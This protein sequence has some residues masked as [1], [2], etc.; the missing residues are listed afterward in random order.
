MKHPTKLVDTWVFVPDRA[1]EVLNR[2]PK[3]G[4]LIFPYLGK[5]VSVAFTKT[6][7]LLGIKDLRF[8]DLRHECASWLFEQ[9]H[10]IPQVASVTGHKAWTSLER[11]THIEAIGDKYAGWAR[12]H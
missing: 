1:W 3:S 7:K 6:C 11:Y 12:P 8:H 9:K 4:E 5:S 10:T 2:Q